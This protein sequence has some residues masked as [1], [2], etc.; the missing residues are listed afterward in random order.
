MT[1]RVQLVGTQQPSCGLAVRRPQRTHSITGK[2]SW[3]RKP[4]HC[5]W[6]FMG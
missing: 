6:W 2:S 3:L 1:A 5:H 4:I